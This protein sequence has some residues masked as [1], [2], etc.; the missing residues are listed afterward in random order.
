MSRSRWPSPRRPT[1]ERDYIRALIAQ[2]DD[3][4][5]IEQAL[6]TQY[7]PAVLGKPPASGFN[8]TI[9]LLP[10]GAAI[11]GLAIMTLVLPRWRRSL[12]RRERTGPGRRTDLTRRGAPARGGARPVRLR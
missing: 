5:Q 3:K 1:E 8:L 2:G 7:G 6:V 4:A 10:A 12:A 11:L 9:Y